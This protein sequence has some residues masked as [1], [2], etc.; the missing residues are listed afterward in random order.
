LVVLEPVFSLAGLTVWI[1]T[2]QSVLALPDPAV[3]VPE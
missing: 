3:F 2:V 1:F